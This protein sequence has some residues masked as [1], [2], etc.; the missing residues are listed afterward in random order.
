M[1][2]T[3]TL[4][5]TGKPQ[6]WQLAIGPSSRFAPPSL[7]FDIVHPRNLFERLKTPDYFT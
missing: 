2:F 5:M 3:L 7:P 4:C 6:S 1:P